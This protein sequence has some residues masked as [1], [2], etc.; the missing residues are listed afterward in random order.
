MIPLTLGVAILDDFTRC[1]R[2]ETNAIFYAAIG[3]TD[4]NLVHEGHCSTR[5]TRLETNALFYATIG[6][7]DVNLVHPG[8]IWAGTQP[9]R[10]RKS[11]ARGVR[12]T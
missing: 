4:V 8:E 6:A 12:T 1:T 2:L 7:T 10:A 11:M 3:A 5:L 9:L